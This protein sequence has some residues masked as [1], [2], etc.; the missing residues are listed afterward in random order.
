MPTRR[1]TEEP[2]V[3]LATRIPKTLHRRMKLH[4]VQSEVSLMDFVVDALREG[5]ERKP[6][7]KH[8]RATGT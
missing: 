8:T 3:Q 1:D 5:L 2:W 4:C 6:G 7:R